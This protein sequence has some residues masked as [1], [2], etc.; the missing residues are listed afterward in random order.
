MLRSNAHPV[1]L[2]ALLGFATAASAQGPAPIDGPGWTGATHPEAVIAAR[3]AVMAEAERKI[4][5]LDAFAVG[6][7]GDLAALRSDA[8]TIEP[9]LIALPHLFPPTTDLHDPNRADSSTLALTALWKDFATFERLDEASVAAAAAVVAADDA[10]GLRAA[11]KRLRGS[12]D[13]C[14][15]LF[16]QPY[17]APQS[18]EADRDFD[19]DSVLK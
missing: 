18:T 11:A 8:T 6:G 13:A 3:R 12:C 17:E 4:Q 9:L 16:L 10:A 15:A 7:E 19:F 1:V 2:A 5:P 14:H